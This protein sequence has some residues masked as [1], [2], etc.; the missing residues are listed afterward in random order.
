LKDRGA[1]EVGKRADLVLW[2]GDPFEPQSAVQK[3]WIAGQDMDLNHRQK[4]LT[5]AYLP[6]VSAGAPQP[7]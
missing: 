7:K 4:E 6:K 2:S 5:R 3:L 1:I